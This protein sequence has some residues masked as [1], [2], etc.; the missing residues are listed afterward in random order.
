MTVQE[1][2]SVKYRKVEQEV[3]DPFYKAVD[4]Q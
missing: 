3:C 2:M 1:Q 4:A